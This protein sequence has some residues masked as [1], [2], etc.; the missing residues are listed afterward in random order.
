MNETKLRMSRLAKMKT[1][2]LNSRKRK[3]KKKGRA[4]ERER[5]MGRVHVEI[6]SA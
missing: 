1:G 3:S 2:G 5:E 6:I 4:R